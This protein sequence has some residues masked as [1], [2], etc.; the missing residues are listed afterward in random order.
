MKLPENKEVTMNKVEVPLYE[1]DKAIDSLVFS[2]NKNKDAWDKVCASL[3][4][5]YENMCGNKDYDLGI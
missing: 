3:T 5:M 1:I 2:F 4:K